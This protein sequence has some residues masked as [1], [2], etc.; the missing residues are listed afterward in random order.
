MAPRWRARFG[1]IR[2]RIVVGYVLL[3]AIA[4]AITLVVARGAL[5]ARFDNDIEN[6]LASEV[7]Q[8]EVVIAEGDPDTGRPFTDAGVLF[9]THLQRVLPGDDGAFF[10]LVDGEPYNLSFDAPA[11]L[12]ADD[13]LVDSWAST[14]ASSF[15]TVPSDAGQARTL[16]VPVALDGTSGTFVVAV[17]TENSR[18]ELNDVFRTLALVGTVALLAS[19]LI[20]L[21]IAARVVRPIRDLTA[22]ARTVTDADLSARIPVNGDDELAELSTTFNAMMDRLEDGFSTQREFLDDVAHELRT[23]ITIIQGH[24]DVLGDDP[25][26]RAAT[27]AVLNDELDRMKRYVDDLLIL[28][29]AERPDFL[30]TAA[31]DLDLLA[32]ALLEK[33]RALADRSWVLDGT[34]IGVAELDE[35]RITQAVLN[36][37]HNA[38]RHTEPGDEIG[39]GVETPGPDIAISVR[40]TGTGI[41]PGILDDVFVRHIRSATSRTEGGTGLG[42]SIVDAIATAHGGDVSVDTSPGRGTTFTMTIPSVSPGGTTELLE[43]L[44]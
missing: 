25:A 14:T 6:R 24:L 4:L 20:A 26:E 15:E 35:Q 1:S 38:A 28:A 37:A 19:A 44:T 29:Q 32:P 42:L 31:I 2:I 5:F 30:Q 21:A 43:E 23:P 17:F 3:V 34:A 39:I 12:L 10:T 9:D 11:D 40:D 33:A 7:D 41:D 18:D 27:V 8:L 36:L 16:V 22:L 13:A